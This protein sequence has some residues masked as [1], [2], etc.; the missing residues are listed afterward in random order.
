MSLIDIQGNMVYIFE[1]SLLFYN[2]IFISRYVDFHGDVIKIIIKQ[3]S[4]FLF[5]KGHLDARK[6]EFEYFRIS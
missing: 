4:N 3:N 1:R 2:Q 6:F 5:G